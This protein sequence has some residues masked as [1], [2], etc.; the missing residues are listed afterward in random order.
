MYVYVRTGTSNLWKETRLTHR[1]LDIPWQPESSVRHT[2][3]QLY[4]GV[5]HVQETWSGL[6]SQ[7]AS[8]VWADVWKSLGGEYAHMPKIPIRETFK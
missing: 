4:N 2:Y 8:G 5:C 7:K 6:V 1:N 3:K